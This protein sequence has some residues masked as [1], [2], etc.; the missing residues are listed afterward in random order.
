MGAAPHLVGLPIASGVLKGAPPKRARPNRKGLRSLTF[1]VRKILQG[2]RGTASPAWIGPL[3]VR[4]HQGR[5]TR[6]PGLYFPYPGT[7]GGD[8]QSVLRG[9]AA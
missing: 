5:P 3:A 7:C 1:I 8:W 4:S 6:P 2:V 9:L